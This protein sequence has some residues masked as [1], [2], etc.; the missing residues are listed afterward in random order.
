MKKTLDEASRRKWCVWVLCAWCV[1]NLQANTSLQKHAAVF[2]AQQK[3]ALRRDISQNATP[4]AVPKH[5][6]TRPWVV[7]PAEATAYVLCYHQ[8]D[9]PN[10]RYSI[11]AAKLAEHIDW[12]RSNGWEI[13]PLETL[14]DFLEG[15]TDIPLKSVVITIDDGYASVYRR[16]WPVLRKKRV[17]WTFF[18]YTDFIGVGSAACTWAHLQELVKHGVNVQNHSKSHAFLNIR[19]ERTEQQYIEFLYA[20]LLQSKQELERR[21]GTKVW[22]YAYPYGAWS[23]QVRDLAVS[24]GYRALLTVDPQPVKATTSPTALG[25]VV[26]TSDLQDK[27]AEILCERTLEVEVVEPL[28][29]QILRQPVVLVRCRVISPSALQSVRIN[30]GVHKVVSLHYD[31]Q[32]CELSA[33]VHVVHSTSQRITIEAEDLS[34]GRKVA[35]SWQVEW[36]LPQV[37]EF[38]SR[39]PPTANH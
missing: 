24:F 3:A 16:A 37:Q 1:A 7:L 4:A 26:I 5:N 9:V 22:A 19:G 30:V 28:P 2:M 33:V 31:S 17:P 38:S 20:E 14:V 27:L 18:V 11:S 34:T 39:Q 6:T 13:V 25:R 21:L 29:H 23:T 8:F 32:T 35:N 36:H 15:R 12:L 10:N